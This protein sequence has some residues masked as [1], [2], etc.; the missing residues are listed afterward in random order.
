MDYVKI[1]LFLCVL[2][3]VQADEKTH[4]YKENEA[5]LLW[6]N[7][8]GPFNNPMETYP[9]YKS[10]IPFCNR[11][12][13][14][15]VAHSEFHYE[16]WE[17]LGSLLEGNN[18]VHSGIP[19]KYKRNQEKQTICTMKL[20]AK[21]M[22]YLTD[23][24]KSS[25]WFSMYLDE[26][27][28]WG[29][30]GEMIAED[31]TPELS[32]PYVY[33]HKSFQVGYNDNR[34]IEV[35]LTS[36]EPELLTLGASGTLEIKMTYS[37]S[38]VEV[39]D[40]SFK[41]RFDRYLDFGFFEHQIHWFSLFNS[42][43]MVIFLVGLVSLILMRTLRQDYERFTERDIDEINLDTVVDETGWKQVHGDV[44]RAPPN[45][46]LFAAIIGTGYQLLFSCLIVILASILNR[47]YHSRGSITTTTIFV[48]ALN[49]FVAGYI[50]SSTFLEYS[51]LDDP[52]WK[53]TILYTGGLYPLLIIVVMFCLNT[54]SWMYKASTTISFK[55]I[56]G[57][58]FIFCVQLV[59]LVVG[60]QV[61][62]RTHKQLRFPCRVTSFQRPIPLT[63]W[64]MQRWFISFI[65]GT[66]PFG[67]IF[68]EM[69]F[70]FTSFWNYKFYYVYGFSLLVLAILII[71]TVSVSIVATY[72]LLNAEDYRW[73]WSSIMSGGS[74]SV[75]V[76]LYSVFY[77]YTKTSMTGFFQTSFYFGYMF[78]FSSALFFFGAAV[79]YSGTRL[80]VRAIYENIKSD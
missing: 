47:L 59:L 71:V 6:V 17:G 28:I 48:F 76:F 14:L 30:V 58:F 80:F 26:L 9:Y 8:V 38:W 5:V 23:G 67:S 44:F 33:T 20:D 70:I 1:I 79:A 78:M 69:Y 24:I 27:P 65:G 35:N 66:L 19:I 60:T 75:Y 32:R 15:Q 41:Q 46:P 50:S 31:A 16:R 49:S 3:L 2:F 39:T 13:E 12:S 63:E 22:K 57:V 77:F 64:Y 4:K 37:V 53:Q 61:G 10:H 29:M 74:T 36:E 55:I 7:K 52:R 62:R 21:K 73:K 51:S 11:A 25:Y 43:M 18:L 42:F 34:I 68:I 40:K 72:F 45:L 54:L 56:L